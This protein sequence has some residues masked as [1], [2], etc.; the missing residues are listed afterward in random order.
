LISLFFFLYLCY[1]TFSRI[2]PPLYK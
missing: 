2:P 1:I